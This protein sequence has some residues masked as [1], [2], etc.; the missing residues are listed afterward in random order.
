MADF[1]FFN[2]IRE[3]DHFTMDLLKS[4]ILNAGPSEK[5]LIVDHLKEDHNKREFK[6]LIIGRTL[7]L[8]EKSSKP[9]EASYK[10]SPTLSILDL[11]KSAFYE[12]SEF[13]LTLYFWEPLLIIVQENRSMIKISEKLLTKCYYVI[14]ENFS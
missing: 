1:H 13:V 2:Y 3:T 11:L 4:P 5:S 14:P 12:T 8:L 7:D 10:W 6:H 9:R